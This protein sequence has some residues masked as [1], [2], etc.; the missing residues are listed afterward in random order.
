MYVF[1]GNV[2]LASTAVEVATVLNVPCK[3]DPKEK[4]FIDA[5]DVAKA[6]VCRAVRHTVAV[7]ELV[8][9]I[10]CEDTSVDVAA[11]D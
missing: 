2:V 6:V 8:V 10:I 1:G 7:E 4:E 11:G 5:V 9:T 3:P